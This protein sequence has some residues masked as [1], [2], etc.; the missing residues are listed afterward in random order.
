MAG[1]VTVFGYKVSPGSAVAM[2]LAAMVVIIL[3]LVPGREGKTETPAPGSIGTEGIFTLDAYCAA[4][5]LDAAQLYSSI[6]KHDLAAVI[7][8]VERGKAFAVVKGDRAMR[9]ASDGGLMRVRI[10]SGYRIGERCW[11]ISN[12]LE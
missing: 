4:N 8:L 2:G 5:E 1:D 10:T 12:L 11:T 7:G 6:G 3:V 9:V